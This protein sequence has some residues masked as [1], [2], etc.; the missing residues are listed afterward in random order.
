MSKMDK[1]V[2]LGEIKAFL[3][4]YNNDI[5]YLVN[6]ETDPRTNFA[7]CIIHEPNQKPRIEHIKYEPFMYMKD[8]SRH[9]I[10]LYNGISEQ[11]L[12]SKKIK[13]GITITKLKTGNQKRLVKGY[14]YKITSHRSYNDI[15]NFLKDGGIDPYEKLT[16]DEGNIIKDKKGDSVFKYRDLFYSPK[17]TEQFFIS[18]QSR[19]YKGYEEYKNVHKLTFDI[20]TTGLRF[21]IHRVFAIGV[22]DNR[23]F[24]TILEVD[25]LNDDE[26][27]IRLIQDFFQFN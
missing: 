23:G 14:C 15:L 18:T 25:K 9:K 21:Q 27:E 8:L 11:Y 5:K 19:L 26:S 20:E 10:K 17:T 22:R 12:E 13:Y 7:E 6:V 1:H 4:G 3:E 24:E 16:D 2:V